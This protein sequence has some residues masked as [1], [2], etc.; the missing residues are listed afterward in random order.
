M[1]RTRSLSLGKALAV[2]LSLFCMLLWFKNAPLTAGAV[3]RGIGILL[4][5]LLPSLFPFAVLSEWLRS[6]PLTHTLLSR[7]ARP[8][9]RVLHLGEA[10]G[11]ALL[12]GLLCGAPVG[13]QQALLLR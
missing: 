4:T 6:F 8:L 2:P 13:A 12:L 10:G 7:A 11:T 1:P 9:C 3:R 5:T